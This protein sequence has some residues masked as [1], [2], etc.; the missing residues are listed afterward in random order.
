M[1]SQIN[2]LNTIVVEKE[3]LLNAL[4]ENKKK[5]DSVL[6][7]DTAIYWKD[8]EKWKDARKKEFDKALNKLNSDFEKSDKTISIRLDKKKDFL[9]G[10]DYYLNFQFKQNQPPFLKPEDHTDDY[11]G[12][13]RRVEM[14]AYDKISL[15][16]QE[17]DQYIMNK[18]IWRDSFTKKNRMIYQSSDLF[19][20]A[21]STGIY[22]QDML[23]SGCDAIF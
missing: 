3:K 15:S 21:E 7:I 5:H 10:E 1:E 19:I 22:T 17:F 14:S 2:N 9:K 13:I 6:E 23:A 20:G 8:V 18:W 4:K 11:I 12:A 16:S